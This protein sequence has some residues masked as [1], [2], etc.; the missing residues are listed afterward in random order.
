[1]KKE[2]IS[3]L[4][5]RPILASGT[6]PFVTIMSALDKLPSGHTLEIINSFEPIPLLNKLKKE[7]YDFE[8]DRSDISAVHTF[9]EKTDIQPVE[10]AKLTSKPI[11]ISFEE[12]ESKFKGCMIELDVRH[13]E[14]PMPMVTILESL[15]TLKKGEALYVHHQRLPQYLLPELEDRNYIWASKIVDEG[16]TKLIIFK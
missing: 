3:T 1:M 6:D 4:D 12:C 15:E 13:L 8:T 9:V 14:M 11:S 7:G 5:V 10:E 16:N 2:N